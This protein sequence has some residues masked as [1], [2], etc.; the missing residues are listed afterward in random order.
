M[1]NLDKYQKEAVLS[2]SDKTLIVAPPGSGKTTVIINRIK[3]LMDSGIEAK[4]IVILTFTKSA[5]ENMKQRFNSI[6]NYSR[7]PFFG[8]FHG[9]FYKMLAKYYG[10]ISIIN[11]AEAYNL[12]KKQLTQITEDVGDD[13][14]KEVL[15]NISLKKCNQRYEADFKASISN[16][17]F[18]DCYNV[19]EEYKSSKNL[20]DFDDLQIK[21]LELLDS[22]KNMLNSYKSL[23]K[24]LLVDEFQDCDNMQIEFLKLIDQNIFCVG[25]EDQCIYSFRG[26]NPEVMVDF[27]KEFIN[28]NKIYLKYNYRSRENIVIT[29]KE[30]ID[31]NTKRHKKDI[32]AY[33][34][35]EGE[36]DLIILYDEAEQSKDISEKIKKSFKIGEKYEDNAIIYRTNMESRSIID[37]FIRERIPFRLLDKEFNFFNHFI[38]QDILAYLKLAIDP[39]DK[40][41]FV[42]IINKPFRYVSK[43]SI[44][45]VKKSKEYINCFDL[46]LKIGEIHPFQV[47]KLEDLNKDINNLNKMTL[48]S[49]IDFILSDLEYLDY[50]R[51]YADKY[52]QDISELLEIVEEFK[53]AAKDFNKIV[54]FLAHIDEV[55]NSLKESK[56]ITTDAVILSTI[57]G[58]K[59]M[60]FKNVFMINCV[61]EV[62]PHAN[63]ENI[64][65]ERRLFYVGITRAI[66][67]IYI[68]APK[69]LKG[70]FKN[71]TPFLTKSLI[72]IKNEKKNSGFKQGQKVI[73]KINGEGV[74][75]EVKD[76]VLTVF[77][78]SNIMKRFDIETVVRAGL[79]KIAE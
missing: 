41:Y 71:D 17:I 69:T 14:V 37:K 23:F 27:K 40:H 60:E 18:N 4:N 19:Y 66:E 63:A 67:K 54:Q 57:H 34:K 24:Y 28:G 46:I 78:G 5:A 45:N 61:D 55:E 72:E 1:Y 22:N 70:N 31:K 25:D 8:T 47:K 3:H 56:N 32:I 64:E 77:F 58:V 75:E 52:N 51:E 11:S 62:I 10:N 59:G 29:S 48:R 79:I 50:L 15:N 12:I 7:T 33:D 65:E 2:T 26:S 39:Y 13:K 53:I 36:I 9:L 49:A 68:Y 42:K 43:S 74:V 38:C 6:S 35:K 21:M 44:L 76:G 16:D 20:W 30:I 73:S